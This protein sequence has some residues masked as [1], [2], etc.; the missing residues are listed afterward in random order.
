VINLGEPVYICGDSV[1]IIGLGINDAVSETERDPWRVGW[2]LYGERLRLL[3]AR[4]QH[5]RYRTKAQAIMDIVGSL[6]RGSGRIAVEGSP[7]WVGP[8]EHTP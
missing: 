3:K 7:I 4:R 6:R 2:Q 1:R 5:R 8:W